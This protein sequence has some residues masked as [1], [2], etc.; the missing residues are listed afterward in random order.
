MEKCQVF[1]TIAQPMW[2]EYGQDNWGIRRLLLAG[3]EI[4]LLSIEFNI[5]SV[6]MAHPASYLLHFRGSFSSAKADEVWSWTF[7]SI[8]CQ[9]SEYMELHFNS[10]YILLLKLQQNRICG[11]IAT[12]LRSHSADSWHVV[13][14]RGKQRKILLKMEIHQPWVE[15]I[16]VLK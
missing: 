14:G 7:T 12:Y 9:S 4:F 1:F 15:H 2:L 6:S 10:P 11:I 16:L 3:Q 8:W 13:A 5:Q